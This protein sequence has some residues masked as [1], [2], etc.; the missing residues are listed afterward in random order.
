MKNIKTYL[1]KN[2]FFVFLLTVILLIIIALSV[3]I[4]VNT[5]AQ[6]EPVKPVVTTPE[7]AP[8]KTT[9][10]IT[11]FEG[12]YRKDLRYIDV[13]WSYEKHSSTI[14][15]VELYINNTYVDNVS[16]YSGY[17]ISKDAYNYATGENVLRLI[18]NLSNGKTVEKRQR[19]LLIMWSVWSKARKAGWQCHGGNTE[20]SV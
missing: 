13:T 7:P 6:Q 19:F 15:S 11:Q 2:G 17:Q 16:D 20:I 5:Q 18:L 12:E 3:Y 8:A 4:F 9:A 1:K 10:E 14:N